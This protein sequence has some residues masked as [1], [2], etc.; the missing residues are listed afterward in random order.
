MAWGG[1]GYGVRKPDSSLALTTLP[2]QSRTTRWCENKATQIRLLLMHN[3]PTE[4]TACL[5]T[6][7]QGCGEQS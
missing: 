7:R 5:E 1:P 4:V 6:Q 2:R 3:A